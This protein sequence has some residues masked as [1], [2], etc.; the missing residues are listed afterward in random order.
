MQEELDKVIEGL[1]AAVEHFERT[2]GAAGVGRALLTDHDRR[3]REIVGG[4]L[5]F[6]SSTRHARIRFST[7]AP[8][9]APKI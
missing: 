6:R 4:G 9:V 7:T 2:L 1:E 8:R 3:L 5:V